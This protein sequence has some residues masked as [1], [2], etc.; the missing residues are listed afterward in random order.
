MAP[1]F[2]GLFPRLRVAE[3]DGAREALFDAVE[4]IG[5]QDL[6][7]SDH[8]HGFALLRADQALPALAACGR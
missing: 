2:E 7:R 4:A 6:A 5:R 3:I 1:I 8:A